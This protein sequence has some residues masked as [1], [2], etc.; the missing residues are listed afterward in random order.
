VKIIT[1][2]FSRAS[3][4]RVFFLFLAPLDAEKEE[5]YW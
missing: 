3:P 1:K 2:L 5:E 4:S